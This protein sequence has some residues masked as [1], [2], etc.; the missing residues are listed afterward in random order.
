[1]L[2]LL[3]GQLYFMGRNT[4]TLARAPLVGGMPREVLE[5][6]EYADW[7]SDGGSL[8]I[9][10]RDGP[11]GVYTFT[12]E[13][14]VYELVDGKLRGR[15]QTMTTP[16]AV[17]NL[18]E[19]A[20]GAALHARGRRRLDRQRAGVLPDLEQEARGIRETIQKQSFDGTFFVDNALRLVERHGATVATFGD[21]LRVPGSGGGSLARHLG[22]PAQELVFAPGGTGATLLALLTLAEPGAAD[23]VTSSGP[24]AGAL[25]SGRRMRFR[26]MAPMMVTARVQKAMY[27]WPRI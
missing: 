23:C 17:V 11:S 1:M 24:P 19:G 4:G 18:A 13:Y 20:F 9:D 27:S 22:I 12:F 14:G 16:M 10:L 25:R 3:G 6:V 21:M 26:R 8:C 7:G 15:M 5:G 2:V